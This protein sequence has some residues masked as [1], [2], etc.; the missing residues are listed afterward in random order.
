M[1]DFVVGGLSITVAVALSLLTTWLI[2]ETFSLPA[3]FAGIIQ[4]LVFF[5]SLIVTTGVYGRIV[6]FFFPMKPGTFSMT[7]NSRD[8]VIW[9]L[10]G[11]MYLFNLS[12]LIQTYLTPV[13]LRWIVYKFLGSTIG[14]NVIMG[15]KIL[16]PLMIEIGDY[17]LLGEDSLITGHSIEGESVSLGKVK[18]GNYVTVG[19]KAVILPDVEIGDHALIA[20]GAVVQKG[21]RIRPRETWGGIPARKLGERKR[22][23]F[24]ETP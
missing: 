8:A 18:I 19:V 12:I 15:G 13:N 5:V 1:T 7:K 20:A 2:G 22:E 10:Q 16:E 17:V 6:Q 9:K 14:K 11:F 24:N 23:A 4:V 3:D 21:T